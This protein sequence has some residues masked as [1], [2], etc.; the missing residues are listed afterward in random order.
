[1]GEGEQKSGGKAERCGCLG[2]GKWERRTGTVRRTHKTI[3]PVRVKKRKR[4]K[5]RKKKKVAVFTTRDVKN[6]FC[7][8]DDVAKRGH[9]VST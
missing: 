8:G 5:K 4:R 1:M 2:G 7:K 9:A 3:A 6:S